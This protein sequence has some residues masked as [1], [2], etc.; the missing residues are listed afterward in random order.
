[1]NDPEAGI[2]LIRRYYHNG[3]AAQ[4][5]RKNVTIAQARAHCQD[6]RNDSE[7]WFDVYDYMPSWNTIDSAPWPHAD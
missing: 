3:R 1:M 2:Y 5:I 4:I 7:Y 6:P